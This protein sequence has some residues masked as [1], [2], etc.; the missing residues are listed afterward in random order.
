M[1][2]TK[3][4]PETL[5]E[6]TART[7]AKAAELS[8][9][10]RVAVTPFFFKESDES[11]EYVVGYFKELSRLAKMRLMDTAFAGT[12][13]S[14]AELV[15]SHLVKEA[16]DQRIWSEQSEHDKFAIGAAIAL[17]NQIAFYRNLYTKKK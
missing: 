5:A 17:S 12:I 6:V 13:S 7:E 1:D 2:E 11:D 10:L 14:A 3:K 9:Q 4:L 16:S 8:I 15:P